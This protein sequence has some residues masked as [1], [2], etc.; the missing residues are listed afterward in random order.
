MS[1][2]A[3]LSFQ[4]GSAFTFVEEI[5]SGGMGIVYLATKH[6]EGVNDL[7]VLKTIR[8]ITNRQV[9]ALK[10][11]ANIAAALRHENIVRT[12]GMEAI[13]LK[14]CLKIFKKRSAL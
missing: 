13:P 14:I 10:A 11:E 5:G 1:S 8:T 2:L 9:E 3:D 4:S 6:C 12:Y 7:V